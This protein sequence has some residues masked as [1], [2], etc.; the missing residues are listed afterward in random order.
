MS[1]MNGID[2]RTLY[3]AYPG[4]N[5]TAMIGG[6]PMMPAL[7]VFS[8]SMIASLFGALIAG[9]GGLLIGLAGFPVLLFFRQRCATDDQAL[10]IDW[11]EFRCWLDRIKVSL[12]GRTHTLAPMR[13]GRSLDGYTRVLIRGPDWAL[14]QAF[15]IRTREASRMREDDD[16]EA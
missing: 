6:V 1:G 9:P 11:L 14:Y 7:I 15:L 4:M 16:D 12:Y 8:V 13:F 5:R 3:S 10:R 2:D